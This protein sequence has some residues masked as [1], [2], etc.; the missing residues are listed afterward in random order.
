MTFGRPTGTV[1]GSLGPHGR[2][3]EATLEFATR[4]LDGGSQNEL[5]NTEHTSRGQR[6]VVGMTREQIDALVDAHFRA[7]ET[8][9]IQAI[10][11]G[12]TDGAEHDVAGRPGR[13]L[14]GGAQIA[15]FYRGLLGDLRIDRFEGVRRWHGTDHLVDESILCA[16]AE[17]R[18]FGLRGRGQPVRVRLLHV[19]DFAGG[20]IRRES[21]WLDFADLQAQRYRQR[22]AQP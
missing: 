11:D 9:D 13:P 21:A 14:R 8:G 1:T 22:G 6:G 17:G 16:T 15:A 12:F 5:P 10:V 18:P 19:F 4:R 20:L 3:Q 2:R 7:E